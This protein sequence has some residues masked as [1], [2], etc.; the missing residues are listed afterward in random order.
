M[1]FK[2]EI[3]GKILRKK[4]HYHHKNEFNSLFCSFTFLTREWKHLD[5][6]AIFWNKNGKSSIEYLGQKS[7]CKCPLPNFL[8]GASIFY[9]QVYA[10][11]TI[12]TSKID[13]VTN[14]NALH[15]EEECNKAMFNHFLEETSKKIE[16]I[17]YSDNRL[18]IYS[19]GELSKVVSIANESNV[20]QNNFDELFDYRAEL[21]AQNFI[22]AI[23]KL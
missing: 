22:N 1:T 14:F 19:N 7:K 5:K 20:T 23:N 9:V 12:Y 8:K 18:L 17:Q 3:D 6:Y 11:D 10:N 21:W 13:V 4:E 16:D 2:F 15:E